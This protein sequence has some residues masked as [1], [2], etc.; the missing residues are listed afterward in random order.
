MLV[1]LSRLRSPLQRPMAFP[2][3]LTSPSLFWFDASI[4]ANS[5][6]MVLMKF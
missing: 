6:P 1:Q 5:T 4:A 3:C 2:K